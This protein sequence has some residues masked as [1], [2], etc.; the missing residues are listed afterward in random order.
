[1]NTLRAG[2]FGVSPLPHSWLSDTMPPHER[3]ST[4][5]S[6]YALLRI[7]DLDSPALATASNNGRG[8]VDVGACFAGHE[9]TKKPPPLG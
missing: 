2:T 5:P 6:L 9:R 7:P 1:M 8:A 3:N 4:K